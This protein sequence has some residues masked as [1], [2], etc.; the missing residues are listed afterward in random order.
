MQA[1]LTVSKV[2]VV[3]VWVKFTATSKHAAATWTW[4]YRGGTR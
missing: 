3:C 1:L 4:T 2:A